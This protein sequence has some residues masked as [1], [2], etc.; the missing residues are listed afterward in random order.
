MHDATI[1]IAHISCM[2][3]LCRLRER[4]L[5]F[6]TSHLENLSA[7][8]STSP[9]RASPSSDERTH[10]RTNISSI[11]IGGVAGSALLALESSL[12]NE[13]WIWVGQDDYVDDIDVDMEA[14]IPPPTSLARRR[15][16]IT[17]LKN[18]G[19]AYEHIFPECND[20]MDD[21]NESADGGAS[22]DALMLLPPPTPA[23]DTFISTSTTTTT[24]APPA[25]EHDDEVDATEAV[26]AYAAAAVRSRRTT[27]V[28]ALEGNRSVHVERE[29]VCPRALPAA[30]IGL[31]L[32]RS[33]DGRT[34]AVGSGDDVDARTMLGNINS[35][36]DSLLG[37]VNSLW[38]DHD[39]SDVAGV[40]ADDAAPGTFAAT[41]ID[42]NADIEPELSPS[43][44][45]EGPGVHTG[46]SAD[47][48]AA[49][50]Q[51]GGSDGGGNYEHDLSLDILSSSELS[52]GSSSYLRAMQG[53]LDYWRLEASSLRRTKT[54]MENEIG[55]MRQLLDLQ[56]VELSQMASRYN[57]QSV[58][59]RQMMGDISAMDAM[60]FQE[61]SQ[62]EFCLT[63][64]VAAV[65]TRK[66]ELWDRMEKNVSKFHRTCS[67]CMENFPDT[68]IMP[69]GH[70]CLCHGC[71]DRLLN[72]SG[73][74]S[75]GA[76]WDEDAASAAGEH[77]C[78]ICRTRIV[79]TMRIFL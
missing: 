9:R 75:S 35:R 26:T 34:H 31:S 71:C 55:L 30:P 44:S 5:D 48:D 50:T 58:R 3:A 19:G 43:S 13:R 15:A 41:A 52:L 11:D 7:S 22:R 1:R 65:R 76:A 36:L 23:S 78:P 62:L 64:S 6:L 32:V 25:S 40:E 72:S 12:A 38:V 33:S 24:R 54:D 4:F 17:E 53:S 37:Q 69:C 10:G 57:E 2:C 45:A 68:V 51:V 46:A 66:D 79:S 18:M 28:R 21:D 14:L 20:E 39:G 59:L 60:N 29:Q 47:D 16:W 42:M 8:T 67:V 77:K 63:E 61:L 70:S 74:S 56:K 49:L 27:S 73:A